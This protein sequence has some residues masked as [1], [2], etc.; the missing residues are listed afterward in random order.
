MDI[1]E[2]IKT[3][4]SVRTFDDTPLSE[5]HIEEL[6]RFIPT[7]TNPYNIPVE[8]VL[9]DSNKNGLSSPVISGEHMYVAAKVRPVPHSEEAFGYAFEH[10]V[11]FA[12]SLGIGT[13][14]IGGTFKRDVFE[15]A[16]GL[17]EDERMYCASP[18]GYP[19][20]KMAVKE[21]TMRTAIQADKRRPVSEL[22]FENSFSEPLTKTDSGLADAIESVRLA[23][24]A[25]NKQPWRVV[26]CGNAFHFYVK[27]SRG[28][29]G[30]RIGD[31]QKI[32]VGIA[33][34]HFMLLTDGS[35]TVQDPKI[36]APDGTEYV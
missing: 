20:K 13:T 35:L 17:A 2:T 23:P 11:L 5:E 36:S 4:R 15:K 10:L 30:D 16:A 9:L 31:L 3:R 1:F 19:A 7:I 6:K 12:W 33:L 25:V 26:K 24:S 32:D 34:N 22:F 14:W 27:H 8:F 29:I 21:I 28:F 18:L